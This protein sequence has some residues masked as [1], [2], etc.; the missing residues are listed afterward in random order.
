[1]RGQLDRIALVSFALMAVA[2]EPATATE[3]HVYHT[4]RVFTPLTTTISGA[5]GAYRVWSM[6]GK[7]TE[8]IGPFSIV[9]D[10]DN[11]FAREYEAVAWGYESADAAWTSV[12]A[13]CSL[14]SQT[15]PGATYDNVGWVK[16]TR[17]AYDDWGGYLWLMQ[18][19]VAFR[20]SPSNLWVSPAGVT[21]LILKVLVGSIGNYAPM[22]N[23]VDVGPVNWDAITSFPGAG[24]SEDAIYKGDY[25]AFYEVHALNAQLKR[26]IF[27]SDHNLLRDYDEDYGGEGGDLY[28]PT[29][30]VNGGENNPVTHD[31]DCLIDII[32]VVCVEPAGIMFDIQGDGPLCALDFSAKGLI[33][34]GTDQVSPLVSAS[35]LPP[36][37]GVLEESIEWR[38]SSA[39][40][41]CPAVASGAH[42]IYTTWGVPTSLDYF[43]SGVT[44][45]RVNFV[46]TRA[47]GAT[48]EEACADRL[49]E[50]V[51]NET[52]FDL[53]GST[54]GWDLLDGGAGACD[55]QAECM[56][57]CAYMLGLYGGGVE[58]VF[59]STNAGAGNCLVQEERECPVHGFEALWLDFAGGV[60]PA[61]LNRYEGCCQVAGHFYAITPQ[62]RANDDYDMLQKLNTE[63]GVTQIWGHYM[64]GVGWVP[65]DQPD[66][67]PPIP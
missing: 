14:Y 3:T 51:A 41:S 27:V 62:L 4:N 12:L 44:L 11:T 32:A 10:T 29:G 25:R 24:V 22:E 40:L 45:K 48:T 39:V 20:S 52:E 19:Q 54:T 31:G 50:A 61:N 21:N 7:L 6:A 46:C 16:G 66:A 59:A 13:R 43:A 36:E 65:C 17:H 8:V 60:P 23:V 57:L 15:Y 49:C 33:S 35:K 9:V 53:Y 5:P 64:P 55:Q 30:W 18:N 26:V 47:A 1:M 34:T 63:F 42:R 67:S 28:N 2:H 38:I 56:R 37:V 58:C